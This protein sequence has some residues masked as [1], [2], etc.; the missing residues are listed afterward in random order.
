MHPELG[1]TNND[2]V[3]RREA[4]QTGIHEVL[5]GREVAGRAVKQ[6]V[7]ARLDAQLLKELRQL[8]QQRDMT[9]SGLIQQSAVE[10]LEKT[11]ERSR[12]VRIQ[13]SR[14]EHAIVTTMTA[15]ATPTS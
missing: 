12:W 7:S 3:R 9:I 8:A 10:L 5:G 4:A 1:D 15:A 2:E 13:P 11:H 14:V 6:M